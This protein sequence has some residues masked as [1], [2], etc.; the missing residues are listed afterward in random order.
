M[1]IVGLSRY[2]LDPKLNIGS[3][4]D[5]AAVPEKMFLNRRNAFSCALNVART[6]N[7]CSYSVRLGIEQTRVSP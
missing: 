1:Y 3:I 2:E 5:E 7:G 6:S 4:N